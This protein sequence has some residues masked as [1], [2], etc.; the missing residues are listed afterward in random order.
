MSRS[1]LNKLALD[2]D[3]NSVQEILRASAPPLNVVAARSERSPM[4]NLIGFQN[5][6]LRPGART[7]AESQPLGPN[8]FL[9]AAPTAFLDRRKAGR[10]RFKIVGLSHVYAPARLC[11][12]EQIDKMHLL[13]H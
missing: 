9:N 1:S 7:D 11:P 3:C 2:Y 5:E 4:M 6:H 13:T 10:R 12:I 8:V